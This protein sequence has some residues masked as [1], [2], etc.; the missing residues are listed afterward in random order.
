ML[1]NQVLLWRVKQNIAWRGSNYTFLRHPMNEFK[2]KSEQPV[3]V[4]T[5]K[6]FFYD[7]SAEHTYFTAVD[8]ATVTAPTVPYIIAPWEDVQALAS[9]DLVEINSKTYRVVDINN[10]QERSIVGIVSLETE[11]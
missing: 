4:T 10:V 8:G 6:G 2:E 9:R 11:Q 1:E 5:F 3:E 7:G